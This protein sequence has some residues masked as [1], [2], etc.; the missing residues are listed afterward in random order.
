ML[1]EVENM[2][3]IQ[4]PTS[5]ISG[6]IQFYGLRNLAYELSLIFFEKGLSV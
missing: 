2:L 4:G 6:Y 5:L 3:G 1:N